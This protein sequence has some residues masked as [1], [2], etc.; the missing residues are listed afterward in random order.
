MPEQQKMP[1]I[2][3]TT[4]AERLKC[5][6]GLLPEIENPWQHEAAR[7]AIGEIAR[8][9]EALP[10][11]AKL[12]LLADWHDAYDD[13]QTEARGNEVQE[14]LRKWAAAAEAAKETR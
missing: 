12:R 6:K 8:L 3:A 13:R 14:D 1:H 7:W 5:L 4:T 9:R 11:P 2:E 10:D